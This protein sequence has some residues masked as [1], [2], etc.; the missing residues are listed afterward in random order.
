MTAVQK[1]QAIHDAAE[2]I[3]SH[4]VD[5]N[6]GR[7]KWDGETVEHIIRHELERAELA[8]QSDKPGIASRIFRA[9]RFVLVTALVAGA[10]WLGVHGNKTAWNLFV[11]IQWL[12]TLIWVMLYTAR[13]DKKYFQ[14]FPRRVFPSSV[15]SSSD[16]LIA[17]VVAAFGHFFY[18]S[19]SIVQLLSEQAFY[20]ER[21]ARASGQKPEAKS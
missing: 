20:A 6:E 9:L 5:W 2:R 4:A 21:E 17:C 13:N 12:S 14:D 16:L 18:A 1:H 7:K 8:S 10:M 11:F 15:Y 3:F 19:L